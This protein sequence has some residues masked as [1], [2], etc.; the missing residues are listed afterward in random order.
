[1]RKAFDG[2]N[3]QVSVGGR[4]ITNLRYADDTT[5]IARTPNELQELLDRVKESSEEFGL[6]PNVK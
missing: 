6:Y 4:Q 2:V 1:M 3:G 5:L